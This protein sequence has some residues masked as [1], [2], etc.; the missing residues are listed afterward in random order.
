MISYTLYLKIIFVF[1]GVSLLRSSLWFPTTAIKSLQY[2]HSIVK[3]RINTV[4]PLP[5][6]TTVTESNFI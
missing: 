2:S 3:I 6:Q 5:F 4:R 1:F